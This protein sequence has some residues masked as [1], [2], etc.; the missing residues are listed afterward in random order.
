MKMEN[1]ESVVAF[2]KDSR[3]V[4]VKVEGA[5]FFLFCKRV[6]RIVERV[7]EKV[8]LSGSE[9][10]GDRIEKG[11]IRSARNGVVAV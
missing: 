5:R 9:R 6:V 2:V 4:E 1:L 7:Y 11:G 10:V 8:S 3:G